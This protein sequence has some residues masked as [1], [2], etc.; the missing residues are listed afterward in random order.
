MRKVGIP[1]TFQPAY[2]EGRVKVGGGVIAGSADPKKTLVAGHEILL[3]TRM[4]AWC[5]T[6]ITR[7]QAPGCYG[8]DRIPVSHVGNGHHRCLLVGVSAKRRNMLGK[9][10]MQVLQMAKADSRPDQIIEIG[11]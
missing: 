10:A 6:A 8:I 7:S 2:L 9:I 5:Y 1:I 3:V 11:T 4:Q